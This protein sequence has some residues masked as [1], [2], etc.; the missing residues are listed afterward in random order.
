MDRDNATL[1]IETGPGNIL[2]GLSRKIT[3]NK[4]IGFDEI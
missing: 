3:T 2:K 1:Y 4:I